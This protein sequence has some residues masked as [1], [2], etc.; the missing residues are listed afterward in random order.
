MPYSSFFPVIGL[1][2]IVE[3]CSC[4]RSAPRSSRTCGTWKRKGCT[5]PCLGFFPFKVLSPSLVG[6]SRPLQNYGCFLKIQPRIAWVELARVSVTQVAEKID[7]PLAVRKECRI[8]FVRV[9]TGHRSA[10]Q[11]QSARGQDEVCGLQ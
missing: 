8:Q 7:L 10:V 1:L 4:I 2:L 6:E 3:A 11:S 9:E 5:I